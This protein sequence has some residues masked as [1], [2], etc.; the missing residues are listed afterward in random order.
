MGG[1]GLVGKVRALHL[2]H[3]ASSL[4]ASK[5]LLVG[6]HTSWPKGFNS[7]ALQV[8][9]DRGD[10]SVFFMSINSLEGTIKGLSWKSVH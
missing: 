2:T 7:N 1:L 8:T 3:L 9:Q 5:S 6:I 4:G 10:L